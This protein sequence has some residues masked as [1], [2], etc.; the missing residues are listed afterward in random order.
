MTGGYSQARKFCFQLD[1]FLYRASF[2]RYAIQAILEKQ[3]S[4]N[5]TGKLTVDDIDPY[6]LGV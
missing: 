2:L 3:L 4:C 1:S 6:T 5:T